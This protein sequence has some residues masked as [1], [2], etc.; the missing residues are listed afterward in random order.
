M[1]VL[2]KIGHYYV[3]DVSIVKMEDVKP[4]VDSSFVGNRRKI[5]FAAVCYHFTTEELNILVLKRL[6]CVPSD[7][8]DTK[9]SAMNRLN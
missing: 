5:H 6:Y 4:D 3:W 7:L 2:H 1:P 9:I 8:K